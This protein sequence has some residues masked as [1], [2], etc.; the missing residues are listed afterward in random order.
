MSA[1]DT[2]GS[3]Y[4]EKLPGIPTYTTQQSGAAG[5]PGAGT[6]GAEQAWQMAANLASQGTTRVLITSVQDSL[7][8]SA[9]QDVRPTDVL[10]GGQVGLYSGNAG[11]VLSG[12][13]PHELYGQ[14]GAGHGQAVTPHHPNALHAP[15][16]R[17]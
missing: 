16:G 9:F 11:D 8:N 1:Y 12:G 13:I 5:S 3:G 14:T 2:A 10:V 4:T 17:P 15:D 7:V 6:D